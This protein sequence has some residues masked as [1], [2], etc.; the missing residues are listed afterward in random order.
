MKQPAP[1]RPRRFSPRAFVLASLLAACASP[2]ARAEDA[3]AKQYDVKIARKIEVGTKYALT[4]DGALIRQV[5]LSAGG[6][7]KQQPDDGFGIHLEGTVEV[8]ALDSIGEEAKVACTVE[9]CTRITP[10]GETELV[11]KGQVILAEGKGKD[12]VFSLKDGGELPKEATE[13]L[14]LAISLD[15]GDEYTDDEMF[16][17]KDKQKVGGSWPVEREKVARDAG[18]VGVIIKPEDVEGSFRLDGLEKTGGVECLKVSGSL[19]MKKL[20]RKDDEDDGLPEGFTVES[21]SMEAKYGGLFPLD[22][23]VGSLSE[24]ASMTF[25]TKVK[26]KGG[27]DNKQELTVESKVQRAAEMKRR[28]LK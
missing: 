28:F 18:R 23:S 14:D 4:A 16:G 20:S 26:G 5:S 1:G 11:P 9:K 2:A 22:P 17:T 6:E 24:S 8:L 15:T 13:A 7:T 25:V 19:K 21:G 12:T 27:A 10:K 3:G